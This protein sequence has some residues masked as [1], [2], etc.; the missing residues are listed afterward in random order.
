MI[1]NPKSWKSFGPHLPCLFLFHLLCQFVSPI[2]NVTCIPARNRYL[3]WWFTGYWRFDLDGLGLWGRSQSS[4]SRVVAVRL[5]G[6]SR[7]V[8]GQ[9]IRVWE[10][11]LDYSMLHWLL[12]WTSKVELEFCQELSLL[13]YLAAHIWV[14]TFNQIKIGVEGG[15]VGVHRTITRNLVLTEQDEPL[16]ELIVY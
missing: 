8:R 7:W 4:P 15:F 6:S 14:L 12:W 16:I 9:M 10:V 1:Q 11:L 5:R 2:S 13:L 3:S